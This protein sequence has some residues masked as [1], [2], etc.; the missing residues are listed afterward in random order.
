MRALILSGVLFL[1]ACATNLGNAIGASYLTIQTV[2][3]TIK[4]ECGNTVPDGPCTFD[5]VISTEEK[6]RYKG[7]L[8]A[9]LDDI[10]AANGLYKAG[11]VFEAGNYLDVAS[12]VLQ[13]IERQLVERGVSD[14]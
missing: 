1:A 2:A 11:D 10:D 4:Q 3:D 14:E 5:S 12:G 8:S 9:A 13:E 7:M 6:N